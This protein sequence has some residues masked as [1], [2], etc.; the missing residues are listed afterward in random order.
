MPFE[1]FFHSF[2]NTLNITT[3]SVSSTSVGSLRFS[4]LGIVHWKDLGST[5]LTLNWALIFT[6]CV[7]VMCVCMYIC[8]YVHMECVLCVYVYGG[9]VCD[10]CVYAC[11]CVRMECV[12]C[13]YVCMCV[14]VYVVSK[15]G[16]LYG[17]MCTYIHI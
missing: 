16:Q 15:W 9:C 1:I 3:N 14:G 10:V 6:L 8:T 17:C 5:A 2:K 7:C 12:L 13:V 11:V 4:A